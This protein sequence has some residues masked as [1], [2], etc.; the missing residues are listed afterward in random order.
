MALKLALSRHLRR[1]KTIAIDKRA[2]VA[3]AGETMKVERPALSLLLRYVVAVVLVCLTG[4]WQAV[5]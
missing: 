3:Q 5:S 4:R 1:I 2:T